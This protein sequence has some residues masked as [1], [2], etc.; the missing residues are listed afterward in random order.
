[1]NWAK[2]K[3]QVEHII[4]KNGIYLQW[5]QRVTSGSGAY[6]ID[7][8]T[9]YGYGDFIVYW[10][11]GSV[12]AIVEPIRDQ[13]IVIEPGFYAEDYIRLW[14][15]PD[16]TIEHFER[17]IYPS[18]SG[19]LYHIHPVGEWTVGGE[20]VSKNVLCRRLIPRSGSQY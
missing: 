18:G 8:T 14:V 15:D 13:D 17:V 2:A 4:S 19:I 11:T 16:E 9:T 12:K 7:D 3:R 5:L 10:I 20:T 6:D 1:M